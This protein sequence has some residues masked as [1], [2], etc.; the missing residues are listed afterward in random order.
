MS[1]TNYL[2]NDIVITNYKGEI[3][4]LETADTFSLNFEMWFGEDIIK[5]INNKEITVVII[6]DIDNNPHIHLKTLDID[7]IIRAQK[8]FWRFAG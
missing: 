6:K 3:L 8:A 1:Q 7:L 5:E 4:P 2:V